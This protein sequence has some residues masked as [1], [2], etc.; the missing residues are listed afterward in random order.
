MI[1][2]RLH[3]LTG[4]CHEFLALFLATGE[5]FIR[6]LRQPDAKKCYFLG[7][8]G[9]SNGMISGHLQNGHCFARMLK[10]GNNS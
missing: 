5:S 3:H 2:K 8:M 1:F 4:A 10:A 9:N 6:C 7:S